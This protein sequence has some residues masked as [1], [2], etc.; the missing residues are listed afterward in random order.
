MAAAQHNVAALRRL[1]RDVV[2]SLRKHSASA[3]TLATY[4]AFM[5]RWVTPLS[6]CPER[7][8]LQH[9]TGQAYATRLFADGGGLQL[10]AARERSTA[11]HPTWT[12]KLKDHEITVTLG[13]EDP[14]VFDARD[15]VALQAA[16]A[17]SLRGVPMP[18]SPRRSARRARARRA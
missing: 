6:T 4:L 15:P 5:E 9:G 17:L 12:V 3:D 14:Q 16:V 10:E 1:E 2:R 7:R 11:P 13:F 8:C 18:P